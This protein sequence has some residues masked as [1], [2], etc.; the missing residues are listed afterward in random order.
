MSMEADA[1][2]PDGA[3]QAKG[4]VSPLIARL[5]YDGGCGVVHDTERVLGSRPLIVGRAAEDP[6]LLLSDP[7]VSRQHARLWQRSHGGEIVVEDTSSNGTYV[8]GHRVNTATLQAG[9]VVRLGGSF[10]V[11]CRRS[12]FVD[13]ASIPSLSGVS[14]AMCKLRRHVERVA[15]SSATVLV[16]GESGT[17]KELVAQAIH[18]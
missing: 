10:L 11:I 9:D 16:V 3:E 17:G 12:K 1:T 4:V 7:K 13:D 5:V 2:L 6:D 14:E 18:Q 8:N 15:S